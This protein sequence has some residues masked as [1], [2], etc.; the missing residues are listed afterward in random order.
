MY[1]LTAYCLKCIGLKNS[2]C[3]CTPIG[4][5]SDRDWQNERA[6]VNITVNATMENYPEKCY[7]T[8]ILSPT[9]S[10]SALFSQG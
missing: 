3:A 6:N 9:S 2:K 1:K 5:R 4:E 7:T 8:R 10:Y